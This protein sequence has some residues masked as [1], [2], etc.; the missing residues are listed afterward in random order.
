MTWRL[1][2]RDGDMNIPYELNYIK[3]KNI[4]NNEIEVYVYCGAL[5]VGNTSSQN[6]E[7]TSKIWQTTK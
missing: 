4:Y 7:E 5:D 2:Q 3:G 1:Y 6:Y